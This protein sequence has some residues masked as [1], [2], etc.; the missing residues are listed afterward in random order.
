[1]SKDSSS[2]VVVIPPLVLSLL[3]SS[4]N[5]RRKI[6]RTLH[7]FHREYLLHSI[8][9]KAKNLQLIVNIDSVM[10]GLAKFLLFRLCTELGRCATFPFLTHLTGGLENP[11]SSVIGLFR[12]E[13]VGSG[14]ISSNESSPQ[15]ERR[16]SAG[17]NAVLLIEDGVSDPLGVLQKPG[18]TSQPPATPQTPGQRRQARR[19]S[20]LELSGCVV[21]QSNVSCDEKGVRFYFLLLFWAGDMVA[22]CFK[23]L[24]M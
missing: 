7:K 20:M 21:D 13:S 1:M 14:Q 17:P 6:V 8:I 2:R 4:T 5:L 22:G 12:R 9:I 24:C 11:R 23:N 3:M 15:R 18:T 19:G 10:Y 16:G